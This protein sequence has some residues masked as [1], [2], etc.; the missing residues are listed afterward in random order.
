MVYEKPNVK[1]TRVGMAGTPVIHGGRLILAIVGT[2]LGKNTLIT[3]ESVVRGATTGVEDDLA[4]DNVRSIVKIGMT[5]NAKDFANGVDYQL[6]SEGKIDWSIT[7]VLP[8]PELDTPTLGGTGG[9][10][11][12]TG[13]REYVITALD[14]N[15]VQTTVSAVV[16]IN[17]TDTS[18]KVT[19]TWGKVKNASGYK[20]YR[21][22]SGVSGW[23]DKLRASV[24][25]GDTV[26]YVD[27]GSAVGAGTP[28]TSNDTTNS[29]LAGSTYYV[30]YYYAVFTYNTPVAYYNMVEV[31]ND[32]GFGSDLS[33]AARLAF[34]PLGEGNGAPKIVCVA[35]QTNTITGFTT[36]I[37]KLVG[38]DC[39]LVCSMKTSSALNLVGIAHAE[40][41]SQ[42]D[43]KKERLYIYSVPSGAEEGDDTTPGTILYTIAQAQ[44]SSRAICV[45]PD[46]SAV[47]VNSMENATTGLYDEDVA[48]QCHWITVALG[49][50]IC[51]LADVATPLTNKEIY[52]VDHGPEGTDFFEE[53][54][55]D[56]FA[57][58]GGCVVE[59]RQ[60][61]PVVRH[62][63]TTNTSTIEEQEISIVLAEDYMRRALRQAH[64]RFIGRKITDKLLEAVEGATTDV[65]GILIRDEIIRSY[66]NLVVTQDPVE[67]TRVNVTFIYEPIYA[68]NYIVFSYSFDLE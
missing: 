57:E 33:N 7:P 10:W 3:N 43:E 39:Q 56:T 31:H 52:G 64:D 5:S 50:R 25:S 19:L 49:G 45:V 24:A 26:T 6:T 16:S 27:D 34:G 12:S 51:S 29:P 53:A 55:K 21:R 62:G 22:D 37:S 8:P 58:A 9:T 38:T 35:P 11:G 40:F 63:I 47:R 48:S 46:N 18:K 42:D 23:T 65:L 36:A 41:C 30:T 54:E 67:K 59:N 32:H 14:Q 17:V 28:P 13:V 66:S 61:Q 2:S 44:D 20:I 60:G 4:K 68:C 1:A 15:S